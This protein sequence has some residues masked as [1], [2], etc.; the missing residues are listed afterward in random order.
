MGIAIFVAWLLVACAGA[1]ATTSPDPVG[2]E[3]GVTLT[4]R[5][6]PPGL[7]PALDVACSFS[8]PDGVPDPLVLRFAPAPPGRAPWVDQIADVVAVDATGAVLTVE[9]DGDALRI[10]T[11]GRPVVHVGWHLEP[12][13]RLLTESSRFGPLWNT[14]RL[15]VPGHAVVPRAEPAG[16]W[17]HDVRVELGT[18]GR[19]PVRS[20]LPD[21]T[22]VTFDDLVE[23]AFFAGGWTRVEASEGG[24]TVDVWAAPGL[25]GLAAPIARTSARIVHAQADLLGADSADRSTVLLLRRDDDEE[26]RSGHGRVGGFVLELGVDADIEGP[27]LIELI[28]HENLHRLIG[29]RLRFSARDEYATLWF[30]EGVTDYLAVRT[31]VEAGLLPTTRL[32]RL[33]GRAITSYRANPA[34]PMA[35]EDTLREGFWEDRDLRRLPYDKGA[36]LGVL[37]DLELREQYGSDLGTWV[38][39]LR[40]DPSVRAL[41]VTGATLRDGLERHTGASWGDFWGR[42][43]EGTEWLPMFERLNEAG[44]DVVERLEPAPWFGF[45]ATVSAT[46]DWVIGEVSPGS[47][48]ARVGLVAGTPLAGPPWIP[49]EFAEGPARVVVTSSRGGRTVTVPADRGQRRIYA[50]VERV[51]SDADYRLRFGLPTADAPGEPATR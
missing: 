41:P 39:S 22:D 3:P 9:R 51:G 5:A 20:T 42:Y 28:A 45:H 47:P 18:D 33:I 12:S 49:T 11:G 23:S 29:H 50:L 17:S 1:P 10:E 2:A 44:L 7:G 26:A 46:G 36:L 6:S 43:V 25:D 21:L 40:D 34:S 37:I 30:R 16:T 8:R 48:A 32:F 19:W 31:M 14:E 27:E 13:D 24:S 4:L 38:R 35:S 15:Y